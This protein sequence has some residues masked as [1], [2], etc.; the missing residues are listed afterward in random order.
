[1]GWRWVGEA[2]ERVFV[3]IILRSL[4]FHK[5]AF[6]GRPKPRRG[7]GSPEWGAPE[8]RNLRTRGQA[9]SVAEEDPETARGGRGRSPKDA[10]E[11]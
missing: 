3:M 5:S 8:G 9:S 1:M 7:E 2:Q 4:I 11:A 6:S 10:G